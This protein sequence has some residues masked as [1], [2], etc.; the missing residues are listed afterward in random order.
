[1]RRG[2]Q[3]LSSNEITELVFANCRP[4]TPSRHLRWM[5]AQMAHSR[6]PRWT[7]ER[8]RCGHLGSLCKL[9]WRRIW[10]TALCSTPCNFKSGF[11]I[12]G[13]SASLLFVSWLLRLRHR[14]ESEQDVGINAL[15]YQ[16]LCQGTL[17]QNMSA[18]RNAGPHATSLST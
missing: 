9:P 18:K 15:S 5:S 13:V 17:D 2:T 6:L 12:S 4:E 11:G 7:R 10:S 14:S 8:Q 16:S 1:M 3:T